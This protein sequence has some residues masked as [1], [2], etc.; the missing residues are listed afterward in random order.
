VTDAT[1]ELTARR[2]A[3]CGRLAVAV[4]AEPCPHC[5]ALGGEPVSVSGRARLVSWTVIRIAPARY[6]AEAPYTVAVVELTE[7]ARLTGRVAGDPEALRADEDLQL[8]SV[9]PVRGPIFRP[10]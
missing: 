9:D 4:S 10:A 5:G 8:V 7:G 1:A 2:C 6:A 3:G